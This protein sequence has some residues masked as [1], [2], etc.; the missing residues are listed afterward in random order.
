[1]A[2]LN[3]AINAAMLLRRYAAIATSNDK[4]NAYLKFSK[5]QTDY[6][7][8]NNPM[9][10]PYVVGMNPN[11][12]HNPHSALASGGNDISNINTSPPA[13]AY[14]L[15]GGVVGGPDQRDR[16][17]DIRDD[18]PQTEIAIDY[19]APLLTLAAMNV[20]NDTA[21]PFYTSLQAGAYDSKKPSGHPC[22]PV[23]SCSPS[24]SSGGKIAIAV[25]VTVVGLGIIGGIVYLVLRSRRPKEPSAPQYKERI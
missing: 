24:L 13:E 17:Y 1:L 9:S 12:P 19:N 2:T 10:V 5:G 21:D 6:L 18:W 8:G 3:P 7:L 4:Q 25:V 22:D 11:S 14:V 16:Y 15:Y 20:M 23:Y